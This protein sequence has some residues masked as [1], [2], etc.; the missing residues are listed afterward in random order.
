MAELNLKQLME[1]KIV[2]PAKGV[3]D[4]TTYG[5]ELR[6]LD[7]ELETGVQALYDDEAEA[8]VAF[9]FAKGT[10][11]E[12]KAR[13]WVS[14][15]EA[16]GVNLSISVTVGREQPATFSLAGGVSVS[17][18]VEDL[19]FM[20]VESLLREALEDSQVT[21]SDGSYRWPWLVDVYVDF[22]IVALG[23]RYYRVPYTIDDQNV[24][25][26]GDLEEVTKRWEPVSEL[27]ALGADVGGSPRVFEMCLRDPVGLPADV[28][29]A[30]DGLIWKEIFRVGTTYRPVSGE[31]L[32]VGQAMID[33]MVEAFDAG[34]LN[35]VAITD[36]THHEESSGIVPAKDTVGFVQKLV[37]VGEHQFAGLD[38]RD[39]AA[40]TKLD[41]GLIR[42]CSVYVWGDFHDRKDPDKVW[43]WVLVHLLLTNYPQLP[44][45]AGFGVEPAAVAA[46]FDGVQ[47]ERYREATMSED[48]RNQAPR[49]EP[50]LSAE[51]AALLA[52]AKALQ[53]QGFALDGALEQQAQ[54]RQKARQL[55]VDSIVAALEGRTQRE[56]VVIVEDT[57]HYPAV[58]QAVEAALRGEGQ[59]AGFD[60]ADDGT[61]TVDAVVLSIVNALPK[62]AR[63]SLDAPAQ[64]DR[65]PAG[66][67]KPEPKQHR[68]TSL[69]PEQAAQVPDE[70]IDA[71]AA[72]LGV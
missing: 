63:F 16:N 1:T 41:D 58:V 48:T 57:R 69:S 71:F 21:M 5:G 35:H 26:F 15:A 27:T 22:V 47:F 32:D 50:P 36:T 55:E 64:P 19:T 53:A 51:D 23:A 13:E 46:S 14:A 24:V 60:V 44:D 33:G 28:A 11:T 17:A 6:L 45:L 8:I 4:V 10:F 59:S 12:E 2:I 34:V 52:Q 3:S 18:A 67:A 7:S 31:P 25:A 66:D 62:E 38:V 54:M 70:D 68:T 9:V 37:N 49:G 56:D 29:T 40:R 65:R 43:D 61:S 72:S 30:D 20:D 42:D 39:E